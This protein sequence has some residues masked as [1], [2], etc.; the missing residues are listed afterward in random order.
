MDFSA[1]NTQLQIIEKSIKITSPV[2][3][4]V[5]R[6][7]WGAPAGAINDLPAVINT[8][9]EPDRV[10]GFGSR[11]QSMRIVVQLLAAR[12]RVEDERAAEIATALWFAARDAFDKA[13]TINGTTTFATLQGAEPTVPVILTHADIAYIGFNAYLTIKDVEAFVF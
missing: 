1:F 3:L 5:K 6:A 13:H 9:T 8:L 10:L 7:Y 12:A 2:T 4:Q 11:Q